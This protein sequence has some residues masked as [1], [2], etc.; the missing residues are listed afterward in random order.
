MPELKLFQDVVR[1]RHSVRSFRPEP[2]PKAV[3]RSVLE[4]AQR[5]PSNCNTQPWLV[6]I[7]SGAKRNALSRALLAANEAGR[8]TSDFSFASSSY[9]GVFHE[10]LKAQGA[11]YYQAIGIAREDYD[12]RRTASLRNLE[13]FG[14]PHI[15]LLFMPLVGDGVRAASDVGMYAQTLLLSL[16]AHG[17]GG[18][19]QTSLGMYADT[20]REELGIDPSQKMLFGLSFGYPDETAPANRYRIGKASIDES[21]TFHEEESSEQG[22]V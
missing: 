5:S 11:A 9:E 4:D 3:L 1:A 12:E 19:P 6:H 15:A 22:A 2:I 16:T 17:L 20:I 13:F 10:R 14:A 18:I 21:V 7:V 8:H